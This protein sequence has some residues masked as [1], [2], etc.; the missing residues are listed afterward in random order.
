MILSN[1]KRRLTRNPLK[2]RSFE[3]SLEPMEESG[4]SE[5]EKISVEKA[6]KKLNLSPEASNKISD[7]NLNSRFVKSK[8]FQ[9]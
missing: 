4:I 5:K 2:I 3:D 9:K 8:K 1:R 6:L 7:L